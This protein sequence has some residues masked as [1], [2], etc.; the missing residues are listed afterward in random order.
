MIDVSRI[1]TN[2]ESHENGIWL[3]KNNNRVS[4]PQHGGIDIFGV[5]YDSF[6]FNHRNRLIVEAMRK[7]PP[8]GAVLDVGGGNGFVSLA[9]KKEGIDVV[10]LEPW[11]S[12]ALNARKR[13]V[14]CV[15]CSSLED[16]G[17]ISHSIPAIGIFDVLEHME[18]DQEI[19]KLI[20]TLLIPHGRIY[21]TVPAFRFLWSIE[22]VRYEHHRRYTL[23]LLTSRLASNGFEIEF[24]TYIFT[25]LPI[26]V[27]L[28]RTIPT[29]LG[30]DVN[31]ITHHVQSDNFLKR[32]LKKSFDMELKLIKTNRNI[33][34]GSSCLVV[35]KSI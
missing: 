22:D 34:F 20:K 33:P 26:P 10:L 7:Y 30:F 18:N 3:S 4:Y 23:K 17:F 14:S 6:W 29:K 11:Y 5:E 28:F 15:I 9:I 1:A 8:G 27:F 16:A 35:A 25:L 21:I 31:T 24:K 12:G 32:M 19:L 2:I 13:G